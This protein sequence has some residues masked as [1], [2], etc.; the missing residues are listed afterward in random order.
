MRLRGETVAS[1]SQTWH[2]CLAYEA[3]EIRSY[4]KTL[5]HRKAYIV[6]EVPTPGSAGI[7]GSSDFTWAD[8]TT[9]LELNAVVKRAAAV[10]KLK[11]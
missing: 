8:L 5:C 4:I 9:N 2:N 6:E 11:A 3:L 7:V 10:G 1:E